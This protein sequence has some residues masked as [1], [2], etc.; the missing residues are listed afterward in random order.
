MDRLH[1]M[2]VFV[3]V[4]ESGS[5]AAAARRLDLSPPAVTRAVAALEDRLGAELLTRTTR[6]VRLDRGRRSVPRRRAPH[7]RRA[8]RRRAPGL[9]RRRALGPPDAERAGHARPPGGGPASS[10]PSCATTSK[11]TA[12]IAMLDRLVNLVDEGVDVAVR[13]GD[14][15][16]STLVA[17]RVGEVRR[18]LVA[19]PDYLA[20][21]GA[22]AHPRALDQHTIAAFSALPS[23]R[24]WR[25][26]EDGRVLGV[27]VCAAA[28]AERRRRRHRRRG[29]GE[30]ITEAVS[31]MVARRS[32]R[33]R[34]CWCWT[35]SR[36]RRCPCRSCIRSAGSPRRR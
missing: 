17:R 10:A 26:H 20:R 4:A 16:D 18:E 30:G 7:P 29:A 8:R 14:L 27:A 2:E 6:S 13:I 21:H 9:R 19:S 11:L 34:W 22:P 23:T 31:Y 36:R 33:R 24:E 35:R 15:P 25:F 32:R 1:S 3:A 28:R 12:S 5:F